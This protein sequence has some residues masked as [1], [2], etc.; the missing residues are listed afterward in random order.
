M[1]KRQFY[2]IKPSENG[3]GGVVPLNDRGACAWSGMGAF[4]DVDEDA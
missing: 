4:D 2:V 1:F 3:F